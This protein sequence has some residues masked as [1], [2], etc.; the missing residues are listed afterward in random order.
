VIDIAPT[1]AILLFESPG[2][3]TTQDEKLVA[4]PPN[5]CYKK[6]TGYLWQDTSYT[7]EGYVYVHEKY[8]QVEQRYR[9]AID[10]VE[11]PKDLEIQAGDV[12][13]WTSQ[14][15]TSAKKKTVHLELFINR[16]RDLDKLRSY[17]KEQLEKTR[18]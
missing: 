2:A 9:P 11:N 8:L 12:L 15:G 14:D 17:T 10:K 5:N 7:I 6:I 1:G 13:G 4:F 16:D 18:N 3:I